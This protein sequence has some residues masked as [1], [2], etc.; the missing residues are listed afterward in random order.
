MTYILNSEVK[1]NTYVLVYYSYSLNFVDSFRYVI[2]QPIFN[3]H[4]ILKEEVYCIESYN[5]IVHE[6]KRLLFQYNKNYIIID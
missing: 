2:E 6:K 1:E 4:N 3:G 5:K